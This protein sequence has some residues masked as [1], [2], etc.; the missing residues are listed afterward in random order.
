MEKFCSGWS[1]EAGRVILSQP[2]GDW[3][4]ERVNYW[5]SVPELMQAPYRAFSSKNQGPKVICSRNFDLAKNRH[6]PTLFSHVSSLCHHHR[7][8]KKYQVQNNGNGGRSCPPVWP[9]CVNWG[10]WDALILSS[11]HPPPW[12]ATLHQSCSSCTP[13]W[14]GSTSTK[15]K[16]A[17]APRVHLSSQHLAT[18]H[19]EVALVYSLNIVVQF[20]TNPNYTFWAV[21]W[22]FWS[23]FNKQIENRLK[24]ACW[25]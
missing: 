21:K 18:S 6:P 22:Y 7:S 19:E 17:W 24:T 25:Q 9:S 4:V 16:E 1:V 14:W 23:K 15:A 8:P 12:L 3:R 2:Y 20:Q 5:S 13:N 10:G 11:I